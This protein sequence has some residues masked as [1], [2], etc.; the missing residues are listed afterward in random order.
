MTEPKGPLHTIQSQFYPH[1]RV[2]ALIA[3]KI[4]M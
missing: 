4:Q 3:M 2:E 1:M